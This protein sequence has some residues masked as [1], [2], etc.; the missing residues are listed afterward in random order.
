[1]PDYVHEATTSS[2]HLGFG[3]FVLKFCIDRIDS[4]RV[5]VRAT[6]ESIQ[7]RSMPAPLS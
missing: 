5:E 6:N 1:L 2:F 7:Q 3:G 4:L